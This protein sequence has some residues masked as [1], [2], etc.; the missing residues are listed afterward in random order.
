MSRWCVGGRKGGEFFKLVR[1]L[2]NMDE[3]MHFTRL[4]LPASTQHLVTFLGGCMPGYGLGYICKLYLQHAYN[5]D[6]TQ[7]HKS[8]SKLSP[9]R[10]GL[11][12]ISWQ[13]A[14]IDTFHFCRS[15]LV[16][17]QKVKQHFR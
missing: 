7:K 1:P 15:T 13:H 8:S 3:E 4:L 2:M 12:Q 16:A 5:A 11:G 17:W 6:P 9:G 14:F 10:G